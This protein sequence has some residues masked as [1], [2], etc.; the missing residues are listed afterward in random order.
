MSD[1]TVRLTYA[2]LARA[3][4]IT[5]AAAKRMALR[6]RWPKQIGNDGL[7]RVSVPAPALVRLGSDASDDA[8]V[9]TN[10]D[11]RGGASDDASDAAP[12]LNGLPF[13]G[14]ILAAIVDAAVAAGDDARAAAVADASADAR[15]AVRSLEEAVASL[16]D[17]LA[18]E[19]LLRAEDKKRA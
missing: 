1:E 17:Q 14:T 4:G 6:H 7:S 2:E 19:R 16:R 18:T 8:G 5:Q 10:G 3:R 9:I 13:N 15:R 11:A 12:P